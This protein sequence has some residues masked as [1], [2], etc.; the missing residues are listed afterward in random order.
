M[1]STY[2][3]IAK[4]FYEEKK[5]TDAI[6]NFELAA[7]WADQMGEDKTADAARTYLAGIYTA[8]GNSGYKTEEF[9]KAIEN[10]NKAISFK[11][12]YFKAYYGM[13]LTYKKQE[14][15]ADMKDAMDKVL[16]LAPADDKT[17]ENARSTTATTFLNEGAVALQKGSFDDAATNLAASLQYDDADPLTHY[18]LALANNGQKDFDNAISQ[19]NKSIEL[20]LENYGDAWFAIGQANEAK[21]DAAAACEA[22]KNVTN[23]PNIQAAKYQAETVLKC[24]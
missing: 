24:N 2:Y 13:G 11:P 6:A 19:A 20:G 4:G 21:G 9:D 12:D 22:Y 1:P 7:T 16:E 18:Y 23:G 5:Y 17:A 10:Y 14:K 3:N 15:Y 8:I